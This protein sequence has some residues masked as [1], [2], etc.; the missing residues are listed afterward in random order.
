MAGVIGV[1]LGDICF[2][3]GGSLSDATYTAPYMLL[4]PTFVSIIGLIL[5]YETNATLKTIGLS[6][7][8]LGTLGLILFS[9][10]TRNESTFD[11]SLY[12]ASIFLFI[13]SISQ[14][15][16]FVIW[17][18]LLVDNGHSPLIVATWSVVVGN[19][20]M[21]FSYLLKPLWYPWKEIHSVT[22]QLHGCSHIVSIC[23]IIMLAYSVN[24][25][26][27]TWVIHKSSISMVALY[28]SARPVF[29]AIISFVIADQENWKITVN[30]ILIV[31]VLFGLLTSSHSKR[32]QKAMR[33]NKNIN[34]LE[35]WFLN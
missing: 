21:F 6:S 33:T 5:G 9:S 29:T 16:M 11:Q 4:T 12:I 34:I 23:F 20:C 2:C 28:V 24:Y 30:A 14:A 32:Q 17:K 26:I 3:I 27:L 25:S 19:L 1:F 10:F 7:A 15:S 13:S 22:T 35:R 8:I 31:F 18:K